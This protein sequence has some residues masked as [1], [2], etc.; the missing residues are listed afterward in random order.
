MAKKKRKVAKK[1]KVTR[2]KAGNSE[3]DAARP[4]ATIDYRPA[5]ARLRA[6]GAP[7]IELAITPALAMRWSSAVLNRQRWARDERTSSRQSQA[8]AEALPRQVQAWLNGLGGASFDGLVEVHIGH[9]SGSRTWPAR[10][11]PWE[12]VISAARR[13]GEPLTVMRSIAE[14]ERAVKRSTNGVLLYVESAPCGLRTEYEFDGERALVR[15]ALSLQEESVRKWRNGLKPASRPRGVSRSAIHDMVVLED[16]SP[17][18]L[19]SAVQGLSPEIVH[20]AGFDTHQG[21]SLIEELANERRRSAGRRSESDADDVDRERPTSLDGFLLGAGADPLP[22]PSK[23][24]ARALC[25][26]ASKPQLV[27]FNMFNSGSRSAALAVA[28]G[29][30]AAIGFLDDFDDSLT[31]RLFADLYTAWRHQPQA[32][33]AAFRWAFSEQRRFRGALRG[34]SVVFYVA[35]QI[36]DSRGTRSKQRPGESLDTLSASVEKARDVRISADGDLSSILHFDIQHRESINYSLL[37]NNRPLFE[38]FD[39][40]KHADGTLSEVELEVQLHLGPDSAP[41]RRCLNL[42]DRVTPLANE[43]RVPLTSSLARAVRESVRTSLYVH[44]TAQE[45]TLWRR[46]Y[47]VS[48]LS[49]NEWRDTDEDRI[50]LPSFVLPR[51]PA[52]SRIVDSA[53]RYLMAIADDPTMGFDGY[54]SVDDDVADPFALI[55]AQVQALWSALIHEHGLSYINPPPTYTESSQRIRTPSE[56]LEGRRGTCIDLALL[57]A[58]CLEYVEIYPAIFLLKGHCFPG[59]W[60]SESDH[61]EFILAKQSATSDDSGEDDVGD[62]QTRS[63]SAKSRAGWYFDAPHFG[64][65]KEWVRKGSLVP[66]EAVWLT[67]RESFAAA[68]DS[69]EENLRSKREFD[70]MLDVMTARAGSVT[71]LPIREEIV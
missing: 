30:G 47:P 36:V 32:S 49:A 45:R 63:R 42:T 10:L 39:L 54:Q 22:L 37:H 11:F 38:K 28:E 16:P 17:E 19:E 70:S 33:S 48:L 31:E 68:Q 12:Y 41:Y 1:R 18:E 3:L 9:D 7:E 26:A 52:V 43:I 69:G 51:D 23:E 40:V 29:A 13:R 61:E 50:W 55:D 8:A 62:Q 35:G 67:T 5:V 71:P 27:A 14:G 34:T 53:Q 58:A 24:L 65:I 57:L 59:Y 60:R 64:E 56:I 20:L 6:K 44:V 4:E 46:T 15:N 2:K 66:L 25:S 21:L